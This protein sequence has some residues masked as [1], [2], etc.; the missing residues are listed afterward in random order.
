MTGQR[1]AARTCDKQASGTQQIQKG[2]LLA[3]RISPIELP[4]SMTK[5]SE[6]GNR[7]SIDLDE[8][9]P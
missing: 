7:M 5:A 1:R 4:P 9:M 2:E 3:S 8:E 6:E